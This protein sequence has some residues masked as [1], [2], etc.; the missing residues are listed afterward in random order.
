M[1]IGPG[2][3]EKYN[4]HGCDEGERREHQ[5]NNQARYARTD[6]VA[7]RHKL[8]VRKRRAVTRS[9]TSTAPRSG[10]TPAEPCLSARILAEPGSALH[11]RAINTIKQRDAAHDARAR[12]KAI[13]KCGFGRARAGHGR[14]RPVACGEAEEVLRDGLKCG[15]E[16][17][18]RSAWEAA[19]ERGGGRA[20]AERRV[21]ERLRGE[22][23]AYVCWDRVDSAG[24]HDDRVRFCGEV[25]KPKKM[26]CAR[27][28]EWGGGFVI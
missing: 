25:I 11:Q 21:R 27:E 28:V 19:V 22:V 2:R 17:C 26:N 15:E 16:G 24:G 12:A 8:S 10:T 14:E 20:G 9:I 7:S 4:T 1:R 3:L 6:G 5:S 13:D 23:H 18:D